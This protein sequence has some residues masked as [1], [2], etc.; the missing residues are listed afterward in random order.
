MAKF[1]LYGILIVTGFFF[2]LMGIFLNLIHVENPLTGVETSVWGY[3]ID[4][5]F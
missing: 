3:I 2:V 5:L 1:T 4:W